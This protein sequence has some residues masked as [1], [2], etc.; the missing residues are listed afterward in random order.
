M[1][2]IETQR[3]HAKAAQ[4]H[5]EAGRLADGDEDY[6][7]EAF[8]KAQKL[9]QE[10]GTS[11]IIDMLIQVAKDA[12][13]GGDGRHDGEAAEA[14]YHVALAHML[15][16]FPDQHVGTESGWKLDIYTTSPESNPWADVD[17]ADEKEANAILG[18]FGGKVDEMQWHDDGYGDL[19]C[20]IPTDWAQVIRR[21]SFLS[22]VVTWDEREWHI[23]TELDPR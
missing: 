14:S 21:T 15:A 13:A 4:A 7:I 10:A 8:E 11:P 5:I 2:D 22:L 23:Y 17:P 6:A 20:T 16:A 18:K 12:P 1:N 9:S 19:I 3:L